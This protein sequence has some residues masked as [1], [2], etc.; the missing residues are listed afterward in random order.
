MVTPRALRRLVALL[1]ALPLCACAGPPRAPRAVPGSER[2]PEHNAVMA[3][4]EAYY[5][6]FSARD[7]EAFAAHFW[8]GA[9]LATIWQAAGQDRPGVNAVTVAE[10]V[11]RAPAGPGSRPIF[12]E[13]PLGAEVR[14]HGFLAQAWVRYEA[15]FGSEEELLTWR[16]IDAFNL[17]R[18]D[19]AWR[20]VSIAFAAE[21]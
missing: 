18:H 3:A 5:R 16:G 17:L 11:E 15:K 7:W 8:P 2:T 10:F 13:R 14:V 6:D 20:I 1:L 4:I 12:E 21:D 19:G 9:T